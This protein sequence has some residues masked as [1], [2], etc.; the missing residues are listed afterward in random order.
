[1]KTNLILTLLI[2]GTLSFSCSK[3][4]DSPEPE[5][6]T[7]P[8]TGG[9]GSSGNSSGDPQPTFSDADASLWAVKSV[10]ITS[11]PGVGD[12]ETIIG[13]GVGVFFDGTGGMVDVGSVSLN[14][15]SLTKNA[16]SSYAYQPG[17]SDPTGIDFTSGVQWTVDG[18]N[19]FSAINKT[20]TIGFPSVGAVNSSTT[21]TK[22]DGY[23]L[24]VNSVSGADSVLFL[25]GEV[26][27]TIAGNATSCTFSA[28]ELSGLSTG[29]TVAQVAA[30]ISINE[31]TGGKKIYYGNETV[32]SKTA[33]VE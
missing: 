19:G 1:M 25:I 20:V 26:T 18:G 23:T 8:S 5:T 11:I 22:A 14:T 28:S 10:S 4:E 9:G 16:N 31:T 6:T 15:K 24:S 29:T 3:D 27:K 21:I 7:T 13:T 32:Q 33:T 30:Y 12:I 2:I 17:A